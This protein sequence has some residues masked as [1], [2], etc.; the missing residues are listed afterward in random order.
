MAKQSEAAKAWND[1][2]KIK[3]KRQIR[4]AIVLTKRCGFAT[5]DEAIEALM[6]YE[7]A[8]PDCKEHMAW[9]SKVWNDGRRNDAGINAG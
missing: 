6:Q 2:P 5:P 9:M 4:Y 3:S 7:Q 8:H 1:N